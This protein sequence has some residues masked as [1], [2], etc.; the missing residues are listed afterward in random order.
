MTVM[1]MM[2]PD[3]LRAEFPFRELITDHENKL[4]AAFAIAR[5]FQ[6]LLAGQSITTGILTDSDL[7]RL[8][9]EH[10]QAKLRGFYANV[11]DS[12]VWDPISIGKD[13]ARQMIAS[14]RRLL[15]EG[16]ILADPEFISFLASTPADLR[17]VMDGYF[18]ILLAGVEH[19]PENTAGE[20]QAWMDQLG[21]TPDELRHMMLDGDTRRAAAA[22]AAPPERVQPR[23]LSRARRH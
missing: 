16:D 6:R 10:R 19:G 1:A 15:D 7:P 2:A 14:V 23:R 11:R 22:R 18:G 5:M 9:R 3:S 4:F 17:S 13:E 8:A 20:L 12:V 21:A